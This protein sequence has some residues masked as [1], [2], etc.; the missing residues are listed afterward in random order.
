[1]RRPKWTRA[2]KRKAKPVKT[3][4]RTVR[5]RKGPRQTA[6]LLPRPEVFI[7]RKGS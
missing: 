6:P 1:M 2:E 3:K 5:S 7:I 4:T